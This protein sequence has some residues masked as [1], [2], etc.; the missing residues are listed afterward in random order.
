MKLLKSLLVWTEMIRVF[1]LQLQMISS[2]LS[3]L[4]FPCWN[5]R[6]MTNFLDHFYGRCL[7]LIKNFWLVCQRKGMP[8]PYK[9]LLSGIPFHINNGLLV[10]CS[11]MRKG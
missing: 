8:I 5:M 1:R 4:T 9:P 7:F 10:K 2:L 6:I 3:V 11:L